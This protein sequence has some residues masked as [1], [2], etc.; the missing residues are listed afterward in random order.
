MPVTVSLAP[1]ISPLPGSP[2]SLG[3][4]LLVLG[5]SLEASLGKLQSQPSTSTCSPSPMKVK[6]GEGE[7]GSTKIK[8]GRGR[9]DMG[10]IAEISFPGKLNMS[11]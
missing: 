5:S 4:S 2:N 9:V 7:P 6:K 1:F 11:K 10:V 3:G 8:G